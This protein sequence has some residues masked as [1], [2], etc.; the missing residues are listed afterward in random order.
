[1]NNSKKQSVNPSGFWD[2]MPLSPSSESVDMHTEKFKHF[3]QVA[4]RYRNDE[5][6]R[7]SLEDGNS[8]SV[9]AAFGLDGPVQGDLE[10]S[11]LADTDDM[12][13]FIMPSDPNASLTDEQ[14]SSVAGGANCAGTAGT[15][16]TLGCFA[17]STAPSTLGSAYTAGTAGSA[18]SG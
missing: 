14:L 6:F 17:C 15:V 13:H 18:S 2:T 12:A 11:V 10:V 3:L 16:S 5:A 9:L 7:S 1:M 4:D 8:G